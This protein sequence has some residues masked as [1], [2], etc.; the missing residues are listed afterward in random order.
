MST[1]LGFDVL[2]QRAHNM[3]EAIAQAFDRTGELLGS[4][5]GRSYWD[6][7]AAQPVPIR[8]FEWFASTR[9][10]IATLR[11]F[12]DARLGRQIPFWT[13]TYVRELIMT[14]DADSAQ[15]SIRVTKVGYGQSLFAVTARKYLALVSA[16]GSFLRRKV[17]LVTDNGDG[18]ETLSLD[19]GLGINLVADRTLVSFLV[20]CRLENDRTS[21]RWYKPGMAEASI[22]FREVP[23]EVPA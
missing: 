23:L 11:A 19:A 4:N 3:R 1:Y 2:D 16:D 20:L 9:P 6:D 17:T 8:S 14:L 22:Q 21:I 18:T 5:V 7:F 15:S 13:P 10:E 12:L